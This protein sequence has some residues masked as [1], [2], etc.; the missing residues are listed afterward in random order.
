[1][2]GEIVDESERHHIYHDD[3]NDFVENTDRISREFSHIPVQELFQAVCPQEI[4]IERS[5]EKKDGTL[6][7]H[8]ARDCQDIVHHSEDIP[9]YADIPSGDQ[10]KHY[11]EPAVSYSGEPVGI[12][13][14]YLKEQSARTE[15]ETVKAPVA[16]C[17]AKIAQSRE[18]YY[19]YSVSQEQKTEQE[20]HL[21]DISSAESIE[22]QKCEPYHDYSR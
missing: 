20:K 7:E 6:Y 14:D 3:L 17:L 2:R 11:S 1:M 10:E 9:V 21:V 13:E 5:H 18:E 8:S 22:F 16:Y 4:D 12:H 19:H 15:H